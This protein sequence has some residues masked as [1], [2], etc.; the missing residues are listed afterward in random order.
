M[1]KAAACKTA[2]PNREKP[3]ELLNQLEY[4]IYL[5]IHIMQGFLE[6]IM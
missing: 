1:K 4:Y 6:Q 3:M 5:M 2:A